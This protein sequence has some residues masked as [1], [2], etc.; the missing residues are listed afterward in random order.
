MKK[1]SRIGLIAKTGDQDLTGWTTDQA[2][3]KL[4]GPKGT[5]VNIS[6]KRPGIAELLPMDVMRDQVQIPS[7]PAHFITRNDVGIIRLEDFAEHTDDEL[8]EALA[9]LRKQGMKRLVLDLRSVQ[10][11]TV[12]VAPR[13]LR[14]DARVAR[15]LPVE[16]PTGVEAEL[17]AGQH[18]PAIPKRGVEDDARFDARIARVVGARD[19]FS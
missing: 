3:S 5:F 4:R 19:P 11:A 17:H 18:P 7:I 6:I 2:V 16:V 12:G 14:R 8:G 13:H 1:S 10:P 9:N 15:V